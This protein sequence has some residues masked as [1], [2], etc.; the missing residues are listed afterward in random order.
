[1]VSNH[2]LLA[3]SIFT[4]GVAVSSRVAAVSGL[5]AWSLEV[6]EA[7]HSLVSPRSRKALCVVRVTWVLVAVVTGIT[8]SI[9]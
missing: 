7:I 3:N 1:M 6:S 9:T 5:G 4:V 8:V 2:W